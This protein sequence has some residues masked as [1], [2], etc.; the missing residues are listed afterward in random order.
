MVKKQRARG[1][2]GRRATKNMDASDAYLV[3]YLA[4]PD[5]AFCHDAVALGLTRGL[6]GFLASVALLVT[7]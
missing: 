1:G 5:A 4:R 6:S 3:T 2:G 7:N